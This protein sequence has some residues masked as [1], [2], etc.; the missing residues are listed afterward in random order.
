KAAAPAAARPT[1]D[2]NKV[3][4]IPVGGSPVRG[5]KAAKVT[6]VEFADYQ[7]PFCAQAAPLFDQVLKEYPNDVNYV[8]KQFP[9]PATMH[10]NALPA[11]KAAIAAG[12]QGKFWE[13]HDVLFQ[14][15]RE[16]GADKL[17]EYAGKVGLNV[18]Q[19]EKDLAAPEVQQQIDKEMTEGRSADVTGTP[20]IFINGKRLQNRSF[21]GFKQMIEEAK[22]S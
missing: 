7:C 22:K 6:V 2:P 19:W 3:Y 1:I 21:E 13:M 14:N 10:P 20:T 8:F 12:K 15:P 16:L 18:S 4:T 17:K 5:P 11:A 9:L